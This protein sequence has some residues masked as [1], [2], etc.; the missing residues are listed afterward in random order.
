M[1]SNTVR[2]LSPTLA[3]LNIRLG[4]WLR[5]PRHLAAAN[6]KWRVIRPLRDIFYHVLGKFFLLVEMFNFL[7]EN[8]PFVYLS[9]GGHIENLGVYQL[10]K[11]GCRLIIAIDAEADPEI[12]CASLL[13]LE[14]YARID[15]G[16]RIILPWEQ[17]R[18][19]NREIHKAID[20]RTPDEP[21][22]KRGEH[23][24][25]GPILYQDGS[26]G[27]LLYCKSSLSGDEKDYLLDYKKRNR[28]FPHE[29][30][31]DQF[32]TEEQFEVYR[33][34]GY[35]VVDGFFSNYDDISWQ[36]EGHVCWPTADAAKAEVRRALG[37]T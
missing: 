21:P 9:D 3:L 11:R 28:D 22:R 4:Y 17:I 31:G 8:S 10:L 34:L 5:N 23:C 13:K 14:R 25:I 37:W 32:F 33:T 15:L 24:A 6:I 27:L 30:T 20:P 19:R 1:G 18:T 29:T 26:H 12:S 36:K 16:I 35:H 2:L 7:H